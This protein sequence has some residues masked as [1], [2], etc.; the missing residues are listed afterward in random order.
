FEGGSNAIRNGW[1]GPS[2]KKL[3][4]LFPAWG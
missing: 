2:P 4:P 3:Y 1:A